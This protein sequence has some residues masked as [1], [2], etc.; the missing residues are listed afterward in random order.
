MSPVA[1]RA[2]E[3]NYSK[4][5][6]CLYIVIASNETSRNPEPFGFAQ[7]KLREGVAISLNMDCGFVGALLA[8]PFL[9][10][11][12]PCPYGLASSLRSPQ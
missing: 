1:P 3:R 4:R 10:Q 2:S 12:K 6:R 7:D 9:G 5:V 8:A 11:G